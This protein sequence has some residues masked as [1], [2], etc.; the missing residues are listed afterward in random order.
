[1]SLPAEVAAA[2]FRYRQHY[3][4]EGDDPHFFLTRTGAPLTYNT[5]KLVVRRARRRSGVARVHA[6]LLRH[7]FSVAA[8][9]GG[10]DLMTLKETLGHED[11]RTTA[12]YLSMSEATL[13]KQ[14][15]KANPLAGVALPKAIRKVKAP[16]R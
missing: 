5:V 9:K 6:H 13:L 10:M 7:A 2:L 16:T 3:R 12:I 1:M 4:P 11:I 15:R 8:L 14:Q